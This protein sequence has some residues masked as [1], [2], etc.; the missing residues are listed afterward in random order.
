MIGDDVEVT[1]LTVQGEKVRLGI[2]APADVPVFRIEV[3]LEIKKEQ[4]RAG[5]RTDR[6]SG[7]DDRG[8][9]VKGSR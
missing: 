3:Y 5:E 7:A 2:Q 8:R 1:V 6:S 4:G 9:P